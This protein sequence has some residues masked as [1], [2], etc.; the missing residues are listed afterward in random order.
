MIDSH[1]QVHC[2]VLECGGSEAAALA[3]AAGLAVA[4]AQI[5]MRCMLSASC[6]VCRLNFCVCKVA[7]AQQMCLPQSAALVVAHHSCSA[8]HVALTAVEVAY[9]RWD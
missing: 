6:V 9:C 3:M 7:R 5:D 4:D 2:F 8:A 1:L